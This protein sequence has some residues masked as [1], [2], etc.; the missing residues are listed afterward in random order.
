MP[1][2]GV[3][4]GEGLLLVNL[5]RILLLSFFDQIDLFE[6]LLVVVDTLLFEEAAGEEE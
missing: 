1:V 6:Q 2:D 3:V 4:D 5:I